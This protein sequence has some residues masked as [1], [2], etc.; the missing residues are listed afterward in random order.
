MIFSFIFSNVSY[1]FPFHGPH[2]DLVLINQSIKCVDDFWPIL[3]SWIQ[4]HSPPKTPPKAHF[5]LFDTNPFLTKGVCHNEVK[6]LLPSASVLPISGRGEGPENLLF[7]ILA[8]ITGVFVSASSA[9]Y[10]TTYILGFCSLLGL[11][12]IS[13][14]FFSRN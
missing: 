6:F 14:R 4:T 9:L 3:Y 12:F 1:P 10:E 11:F 2:P 7:Y 8:L 13:P 5:L